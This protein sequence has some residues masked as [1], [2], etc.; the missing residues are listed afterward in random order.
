MTNL[1]PDIRVRERVWRIAEDPI[2]ALQRIRILPLL[3]VNY[4]KA[5][6]DFVRLIEI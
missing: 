5:E 6:K 4:P 2:E 1:E 3:L